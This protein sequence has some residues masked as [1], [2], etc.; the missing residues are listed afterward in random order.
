MIMF[1]F[2]LLLVPNLSL[3]LINYVFCWLIALFVDR[4]WRLPNWLSWF[5]TTDALMNGKG[6]R[7]DG[8]GGDKGFYERHLSYGANIVLF[9]EKYLFWLHTD[10]YAEKIGGRIGRFLH[11][12]PFGINGDAVAIWFTSMNWLCRNPINGFD[13]TICRGIVDGPVYV[14]GDV[15]MEGA[16]KFLFRFTHMGKRSLRN[17]PFEI[18]FKWRYSKRFMMRVRIGWKLSA[19]VEDPTERGLA[20]YVFVPAPMKRI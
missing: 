20:Q 12:H 2:L 16:D 10:W 7:P 13:E 6:N 17:S 4:S 9:F 18:Y 14:R 11:K 19:F 1:R 15:E 3:T 5:E 8:G